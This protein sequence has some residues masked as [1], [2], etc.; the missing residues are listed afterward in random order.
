MIFQEM[1]VEAWKDCKVDSNGEK[2]YYTDKGKNSDKGFA[3]DTVRVLISCQR[4]EQILIYGYVCFM[5]IRFPPELARLID[6]YIRKFRPVVVNRIKDNTSPYLFLNQAGKQ[7]MKLSEGIVSVFKKYH[8]AKS[9][10]T[11]TTLRKSFAT[12]QDQNLS[13]NDQKKLGKHDTHSDA[14]IKR[15][16]LKNSVDGNAKDVSKIYDNMIRILSPKNNYP[17][18]MQGIPSP[19]ALRIAFDGPR[20]SH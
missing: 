6:V 17:K 7:D 8:D 19:L 3:L 2:C 16:Y 13:E 11:I 12:W 15:Y 10:I 14:T 18:E 9:H 5:Q 1:T 20:H 4:T